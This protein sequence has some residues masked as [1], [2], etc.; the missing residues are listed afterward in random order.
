[1]VEGYIQANLKN[2]IVHKY[3]ELSLKSF[4]PVSDVFNINII[5]CMVPGE[6]LKT[7]DGHVILG[8]E[9]FNEEKKRSPQEIASIISQYRLMRRIANGERL[10]IMEHDAYLFPSEEPE[11]RR[12]MGKYDQL[13]V[14]NIGIAMEC[15]TCHPEIAKRFCEWV[16]N[17]YDH[18][19][20]GPMAILHKV[21]DEYAKEIDN[22]VRNVWWPKKGQRNETGLSNTVTTAFTDPT[23]TI[24]APIT[25]MID[26]SIGSTVTDRKGVKPKYT[27]KSHPNFH[28]VTLD[29]S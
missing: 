14:C 20:K 23:L 3:L 24:K 17:D 16:E 1:M 18:K 11:F 6:Q 9:N 2:P 7:H 4:R 15:Y 12:V 29:L 28:F 25:Q 21:I 10:F 5:Q 22:K 19:M 26:M 27:E 13:L 8:Q